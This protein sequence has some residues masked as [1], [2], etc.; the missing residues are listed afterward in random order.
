MGIN[1][2]INQSM[3]MQCQTEEFISV[4][5]QA[6]FK[7]VELRVPK[8]KESLL[9]ISHKQLS[10]LIKKH[11]I[12]VLALN[13]IDDFSMVPEENLDLLTAECEFVGR[14]CEMFGCPMVVAP[15]AR[16]FDSPPSVAEVKATSQA[17]LR[18][19]SDILSKFGVKIG[20]EPICFPEF[21][22]RD[23]ALSQEI[24][25]GSGAESIGFVLDIYNLFRGGIQPDDIAG[26][27][28][29]TYLIHLNDAPDSPLENLHVM[30]NRVFPGEGV[31]NAQAW[32][33]AAIRSGYQ[34]YFS[35]EMFQQQ[36]WDMSPQDAAVLCYNKMRKFA[37]SLD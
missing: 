20:F 25:A 35:L 13:S 32:V 11:D 23:L 8:L 12:S 14:M 36:I 34:G 1:L 28:F 26:L 30:Y 19:V 29:P 2:A 27:N 21:T 5:A 17:R 22:V 4:C 16:W 7:A 31:A 33:E 24:I 37:E 15:V 3:I 6:G 9:H 18:H 10:E